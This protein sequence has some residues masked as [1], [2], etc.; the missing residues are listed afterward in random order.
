[1]TKA[2]LNDQFIAKTPQEEM[3]KF[4]KWMALHNK[5]YSTMEEYTSRMDNWKRH[6]S[7]ISEHNAE[8]DQSEHHSPPRF[9][10]NWWSD[11]SHDEILKRYNYHQLDEGKTLA[12]LPGLDD[13]TG[14]AGGRNLQVVT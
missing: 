11:A 2:Q 1:M 14:T 7:M 9:A 6:N 8:A 12:D 13:N 5:N 10:H 3:T 4:A